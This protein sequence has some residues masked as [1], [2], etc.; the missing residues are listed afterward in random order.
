MRTDVHQRVTEIS[1]IDPDG[2]KAA[3]KAIIVGRGNAGG[4]SAK[5]ATTEARALT[6]ESS[7]INTCAWPFVC[8]FAVI[9]CQ[10][11]SGCRL[12]SF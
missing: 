12:A 10:Q 1:V 7:Q 8:F 3:A 6:K 5:R 2:K 9:D 11:V 4:R